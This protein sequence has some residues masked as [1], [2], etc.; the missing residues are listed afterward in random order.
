MMESLAFFNELEALIQQKHLLNHDFYR[1]WSQGELPSGV[2][3]EYAKEYYHHVQAFPT[4]LSALH[5]RTENMAWR[6]L[7]LQNLI[8][9]EA[10]SPNHPELW[11]EFALH[12]GI[13]EEE[14]LSHRA[15]HE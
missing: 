11:K 14:L 8:E 6:R 4:Y 12:L 13:S 7:L 3:Q 1:A 2:L 5:S 9:E 15:G 10:G